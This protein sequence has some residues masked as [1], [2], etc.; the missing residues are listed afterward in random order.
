MER[1]ELWVESYQGEVLGEA[2][3]GSMA[4]R[5]PE[6]ER[7]RQLQVLTL[8]ERATKELAEPVFERG[9]LDRGN[10]PKTLADAAELADGVAQMTWREFLG[11]IPPVTAT[12]LAK[13]RRLVD[14]S[15]DEQERKIAEAYVAHELALAAFARRCLGEEP[16]D[17]LEQI[18]SLPHVAA[19]ATA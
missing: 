2:L 10:T 13:Y 14:L 5:E 6:P 17:P 8:M 12:F 4:E 16:G 1:S 9:S 11:S 15:F 3:F 19:A 18:L 7:R